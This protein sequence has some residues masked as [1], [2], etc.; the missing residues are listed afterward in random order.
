MILYGVT[1]PQIIF[2][3][4]LHCNIQATNSYNLACKRINIIT[5][6]QK[7]FNHATFYHVARHTTLH[8]S[9]LT[10]YQEN[11]QL[12]QIKFFQE[13]TYDNNK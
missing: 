9:E 6:T 3:S 11:I 2:V 10:I 8:N 12:A 13:C 1:P 7:S 5:T 4:I